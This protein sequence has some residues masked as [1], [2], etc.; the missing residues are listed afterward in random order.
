MNMPSVRKRR[1]IFLPGTVSHLTMMRE[2]ARHAAGWAECAFAPFFAD[3]I[4]GRLVGTETNPKGWLPW[5]HAS[6]ALRAIRDWELPEDLGSQGDYDLSVIATDLVI[7]KKLRRRPLILV[8]EGMTDPE[9]WAYNLVRSLPLPRW[10][11]STAAFGLSGAFDRLC[12]ASEGYRDL[13]IRKGVPR[14]KIVVTGLPSYDDITRYLDNDFPLRGYVL[15]ATSDTR[16]T[17]KLDNRKAFIRRVLKIAD[18]RPLVFKLH[19]NEHFDRSHRE[20]KRLAPRA[21]VYQKGPTAA[22]VANCDVLVTQYSTVIFIGLVLGKEC[23][24]YFN[25]AELRRLVPLQNGG[26]SASH[27]ADVCRDLVVGSLH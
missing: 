14:E 2:V 7:P 25:L 5:S 13:F 22:M 6:T 16:E 24:S 10:L 15:A 20:I 21:V 8:Q 9:T 11:A 26:R 23:H 17:F 12:V 4:M 18:G 3:G 27:I 19:P 1:V